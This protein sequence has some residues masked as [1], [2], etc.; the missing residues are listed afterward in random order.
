M[1]AQQVRTL[2]D[3]ST[4]QNKSQMDKIVVVKDKISAASCELTES[5]PEEQA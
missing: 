2:K 5:E 1:Q 4:A 3:G